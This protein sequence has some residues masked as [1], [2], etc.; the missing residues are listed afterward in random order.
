M[1]DSVR[2][3]YTALRTRSL[4]PGQDLAVIAA[5]GLENAFLGI[6]EH[7]R[8]HVLLASG[9]GTVPVSDIATLEVLSRSLVIGGAEA[10]YID[11]ACLFEALAEVFDHFV[12]AVL[13]RLKSSNESGEDALAAVLEKW[14]QFLLAADGP[15]G[16]ETLAAVFAEL[17]VVLD[18]VRAGGPRTV[19][20]WVG[21]FSARHDLRQGP[22]AI[23]VK[24][25][26]SHT[27]RQVTIHGE[28]QLLAPDGGTLALHLIRLEEVPGGA[29]SVASVVDELLAAGVAAEPLFDAISAAGVP[30]AELASSA[31]VTFDVRERLTIPVDG[32][33]PRIV[34]DSFVDGSRPQGVLDISYRIDLEG[35][36]A[37]ALGGAEYDALLR[38]FVG[39]VQ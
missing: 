38:R 10:E 9:G 32:T 28:D 3:A 1:I 13:E 29:R 35:C 12:V 2:A 22:N 31:A 25:T 37:R 15:P 19:K 18:V 36:V 27:N 7:G 26:R 23:E 24:M 17:L 16:R 6:D 34:P 14:R 21:P 5:D 39:G 30:V 11:V 20:F 4:P 8:T 33:T